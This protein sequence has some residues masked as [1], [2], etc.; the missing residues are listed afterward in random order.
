MFRCLCSRSTNV[1]IGQLER[2]IEAH[3]ISSEDTDGITTPYDV[4]N[5]KNTAFLKNITDLMTETTP[6]LKNA[7]K[8]ATAAKIARDEESAQRE[9]SDIF[10]GSY[11]KG[12][13]TTDEKKNFIEGLTERGFGE[14]VLIS[15]YHVKTRSNVQCR[16]MANK[17]F[18]NTEGFSAWKK[19]G[20]PLLASQVG[21]H[22]TQFNRSK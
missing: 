17:T 19:R 20:E 8:V 3:S 2:V 1:M 21:S 22:F 16:N 15:N 5:Q 18:S 9:K 10:D 12:S 6:R 4:T 14:W 11:K 7:W 13:W